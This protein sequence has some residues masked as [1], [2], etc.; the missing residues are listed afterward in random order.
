MIPFEDQFPDR[1]RHNLDD[2]F[3]DH[4]QKHQLFGQ[5]LIADWVY[6]SILNN[7]INLNNNGSCAKFKIL[8][9]I[10]SIILVLQ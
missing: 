6:Y 4:K 1:L 9:N 3:C 7:L 8:P 5:I 10:D 2:G